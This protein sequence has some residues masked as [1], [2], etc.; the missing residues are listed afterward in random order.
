MPI[1]REDFNIRQNFNFF[2]QSPILKTKHSFAIE[3]CVSRSIQATYTWTLLWKKYKRT[4]NRNFWNLVGQNEHKYTRYIE[5]SH[6]YSFYLLSLYPC[7]I[8]LFVK[9]VCWMLISF[10]FLLLLFKVSLRWLD[11]CSGL[12]KTL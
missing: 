12:F 11:T 3:T 2:L 1:F 10:E 9:T 5:I 4:K 6:T 8:L 7:C